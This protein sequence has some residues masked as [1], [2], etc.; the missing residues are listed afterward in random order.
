MTTT[1]TT[2]YPISSPVAFGCDELKIINRQISVNN[3][4]GLELRFLF[5]ANCVMMF[6]ICTALQKYLLWF[7]SYRPDLISILEISKGNNFIKM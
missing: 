1:T 4:G 5:S 3:V 7:K 2:A 6:Y